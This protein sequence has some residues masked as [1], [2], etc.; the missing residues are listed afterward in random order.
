[1][2]KKIILDIFIYKNHWI[3]FTYL[4]YYSIQLL[5]LVIINCVTLGEI[6]N[7]S[8]NAVYSPAK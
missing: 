4:K 8:M 6:I 7:S 3:V 5:P 1:M 2:I